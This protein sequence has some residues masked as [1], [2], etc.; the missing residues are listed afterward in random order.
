V[1]KKVRAFAAAAKPTGTLVQDLTQ[2]LKDSGT[3]EGLQDFAYYA[4]L[5][6]SRYDKISH[7]LPAYVIA[8]SCAFYST[9][10]TPGCSANFAGGGATARAKPRHEKRSRT[11][12]KAPEAQQP[13]QTTPAAPP[14]DTT[15]TQATPAPAAPQQPQG[16]TIQIPGLP[17]IKIPPLLGGGGKGGQRDDQKSGNPVSGLLNYLLK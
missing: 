7:I 15:Q 5:A 8:N 4:A 2:S 1:V 9:T 12:A 13:T 14:A 17:P 6:T 10:T 11:K 16:T 3:V